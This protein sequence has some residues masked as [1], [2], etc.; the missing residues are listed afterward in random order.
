MSKALGLGLGIIAAIGGFVDIGDLVFNV[1]AGATF[2]YQLL[3][4]IVVGLI[5]II[6]YSEMCGRVAAVSGRAVFDAIRE[7]VG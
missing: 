5:G 4:V 7:R 1:A 6:V 3:W 2:G